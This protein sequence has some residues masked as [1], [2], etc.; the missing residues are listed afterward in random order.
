MVVYRPACWYPLCTWAPRG[1]RTWFC[2]RRNYISGTWNSAL[3]TWWV[4]VCCHILYSS[5]NHAQFKM[6]LRNRESNISEMIFG[7]LCFSTQAEW[8]VSS[9]LLFLCICTN[10]FNCDSCASL[11][12]RCLLYQDSSAHGHGLYIGPTH[13]KMLLFCQISYSAG[14][15]S[16]DE[17]DKLHSWGN[18]FL[19][20]LFQVYSS[21]LNLEISFLLLTQCLE[22]KVFLVAVVQGM[23]DFFLLLPFLIISAF[24]WLIKWTSWFTTLAKQVTF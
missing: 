8:Y 21:N 15:H 6:C 23:W 17:Q 7:L 19:R 5:C 13:P 18:S 24:I 11:E 1:D 10:C 20:K 2:E 4:L 16:P 22:K 14:K 3:L 9:Y 12:K